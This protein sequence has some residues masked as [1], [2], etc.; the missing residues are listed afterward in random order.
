MAVSAA[1]RLLS[2][3]WGRLAGVGGYRRTRLAQRLFINVPISLLVLALSH[4][5]VPETR[6]EA[7]TR[8]DWQGTFALALIL[9]CLLFPL[10][11]SPDLGWPWQSQVALLAIIRW[12]CGC[13]RA[14]C[15]RSETGC[16]R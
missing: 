14:H 5:Y 3:R 4:R 13:A 15:V 1:W 2:D 7:P 10:S 8:I 9:C 12:H 6:N 11:L 16:I